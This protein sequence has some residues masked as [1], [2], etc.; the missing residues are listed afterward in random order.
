MSELKKIRVSFAED[1]GGF[2]RKASHSFLGQLD[3]RG[4][5]RRETHGSAEE[6]GVEPE[7]EPPPSLTVNGQAHDIQKP[8]VVIGRSKDC[9][10][11]W[12]QG[13]FNAVASGPPGFR[14]RSPSPPPR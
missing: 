13:F 2:A 9:D 6:L 8:S 10:I 5:I 1:D 3:D 4:A 11:R 14:P 12:W 7:V